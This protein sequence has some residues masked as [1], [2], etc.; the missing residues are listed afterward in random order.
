VVEPELI[1]LLEVPEPVVP[2]D[3]PVISVELPVVPEEPPLIPDELPP[4]E[5]RL[6]SELLL[7]EELPL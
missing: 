6:I 5:P 4:E 7:S 3:P 1:S 2:E